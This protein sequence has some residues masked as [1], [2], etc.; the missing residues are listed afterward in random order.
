M[1]HSCRVFKVILLTLCHFVQLDIFP[2]LHVLSAPT[3][4]HPTLHF[5][6]RMLHSSYQRVHSRAGTVVHGVHVMCLQ[7]HP[8]PML[9]LQSTIPP[10]A[11]GDIRA[12]HLLHGS[13]AAPEAALLPSQWG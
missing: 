8:E 5:G 4:A 10:T 2:V 7:V 1:P 12:A 9:G 11:G 13:A 6:M 3:G